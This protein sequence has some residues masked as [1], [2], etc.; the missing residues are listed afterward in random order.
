MDRLIAKRI[1]KKYL[2]NMGDY[3]DCIIGSEEDMITE[4]MTLVKQAPLHIKI[5]ML[6]FGEVK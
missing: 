6:I 1:I 5:K 3:I 4:A 2:A